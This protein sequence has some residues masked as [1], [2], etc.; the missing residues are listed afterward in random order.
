MTTNEKKP[1]PFMPA[2]RPAPR[3]SA[4]TAKQ[5][6]EGT[7]D[8]GFAR[9]VTGADEPKVAPLPAAKPVATPA[10]SVS[11]QTVVA[12]TPDTPA[13][14]GRKRE[15]PLLH[16]EVPH[17]VWRALK[18]QSMDRRVSIKY[19]VLEALQKAGYEID[20]T[21]IPEDGRRIR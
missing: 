8:L 7:A 14:T 9:A 21:T 4:E 6:I 13:K 5:L 1:A 16:M 12:T 10:L 15:T 2:P 19:L 3:V 20:L 17:E 11:T 18:I